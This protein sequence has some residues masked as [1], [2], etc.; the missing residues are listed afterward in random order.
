MKKKVY[1]LN[2]KKMVVAKGEEIGNMSSIQ[3]Y[4][5]FFHDTIIASLDVASRSSFVRRD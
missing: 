5:S 3:S 2:F 4:A 1:D